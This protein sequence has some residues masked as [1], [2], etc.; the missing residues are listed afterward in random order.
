[1]SLNGH[2]LPALCGKEKERTIKRLKV[3]LRDLYLRWSRFDS[4]NC[5]NEL[6][7][8]ISTDA[9]QI[10]EALDRTLDQLAELDEACPRTRFA[11]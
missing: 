8:H 6:L 1:M 9:R 10:A 11:R 4:Y 3:E 2:L 7:F 5:G